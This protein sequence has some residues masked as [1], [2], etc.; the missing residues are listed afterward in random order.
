MVRSTC[1]HVSLANYL[2]AAGLYQSFFYRIA[3]GAPQLAFVNRDI[4]RDVRD[5]ATLTQHELYKTNLSNPQ[6]GL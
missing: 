4:T 5:A 3:A 2:G 1:L 6:N